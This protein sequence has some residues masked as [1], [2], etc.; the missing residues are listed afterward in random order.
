MPIGSDPVGHAGR[1][2]LDRVFEPAVGILI[3][4]ILR[5]HGA[6]RHCRED[7]PKPDAARRISTGTVVPSH[8]PSVTTSLRL[9]VSELAP[10][11]YNFVPV[12]L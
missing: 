4:G 9:V 12:G 11:R 5:Q 2:E 7:E 6:H 8:N 10:E 3:R 1:R